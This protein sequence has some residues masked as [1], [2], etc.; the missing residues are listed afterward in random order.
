MNTASVG[1]SLQGLHSYRN[2]TIPEQTAEDSSHRNSGC[3]L[4]NRQHQACTYFISRIRYYSITLLRYYTIWTS[5]GST[6]RQLWSYALYGCKLTGLSPSRFF[7]RVS[8]ASKQYLRPGALISQRLRKTRGASNEIA[9]W[10]FGASDLS[11]FVV[12]VSDVEHDVVAARHRLWLVLVDQQMKGQA[13]RPSEARTAIDHSQSHNMICTV[14]RQHFS[15]LFS[16]CTAILK[17]QYQSVR[18]TV[19][20]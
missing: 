8:S 6:T 5:S 19:K 3:I 20:Q 7:N 18:Q 17:G 10:T 15:N 2:R 16:Q 9:Q 1:R 11:I 13:E 12:P 14:T 4:Q